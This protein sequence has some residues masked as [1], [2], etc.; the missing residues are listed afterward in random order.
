MIE[1]IWLERF[2]KR[3]GAAWPRGAW[4]LAAA[5][6]LVLLAGVLAWF[7]THSTT[8]RVQ[9]L[10]I[11]DWMQTHA[12]D[13]STLSLLASSGDVAAL[14]LLR[15]RTAGID[16][17]LAA[18]TNGG[19][20][21]GAAVSAAAAWLQPQL[22]EFATAWAEFKRRSEAL[23]S[24]AA[25]TEA[26]T[27]KDAS[28][29]R[30][31]EKRSIAVPAKKPPAR[32]VRGTEV[33]AAAVSLLGD[34]HKLAAAID[35]VRTTL[36]AQQPGAPWLLYLAILCALLAV[37][38]LAVF[39]VSVGRRDLALRQAAERTNAAM[40]EVLR[41]AMKTLHIDADTA[42]VLD[43]VALGRRLSAEIVVVIDG[44]R[45]LVRTLETATAEAKI[46]AAVGRGAAQALAVAEKK[47][48]D[49]GANLQA[50]VRRIAA[51]YGLLSASAAEAQ[52]Q[53]TQSLELL[54]IG[55]HSTGSFINLT[56][57][58]R[59]CMQRTSERYAQVVGANTKIVQGLAEISDH[60]TLAEGLA[61]RTGNRF[62][63]SGAEE[64]AAF[65]NDVRST[66]GTSVQ[67]CK[68]ITILAQHV[69]AHCADVSTEMALAARATADQSRIAEDSV[70]S[71]GNVAIAVRELTA[72]IA[73]LS[74]LASG[75][76]AAQLF[77]T[78][79]EIVRQI[80]QSS[81]SA[82]QVLNAI[83]NAA[84]HIEEL[85]K[86]LNTLKPS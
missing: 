2:R 74:R 65:A 39:A 11:M 20:Y 54:G 40:F 12:R 47:G 33:S 3:G 46:F 61:L 51:A 7:S 36:L 41:P 57:Q 45:T 23:L 64:V 63:G 30:P 43:P 58:V 29:R 68:R 80:A 25:S 78:L 19:T 82:Q 6:A 81:V 8:D 4:W 84:D 62:A 10:A 17:G 34:G 66:L 72:K 42:A 18:L 50:T 15:D 69:E 14:N 71:L 44:I 27:T 13:A 75:A 79:D 31:P 52:Q 22:N 24:A 76:E 1:S 85:T 16:A 56:E 53:G 60:L 37:S 35:N 9:Q 26:R 55:Q 21:D 49:S 59:K 28:P 38:V 86:I 83:K 32:A 5:G 67:M 48:A 70:R 77:S 73:A